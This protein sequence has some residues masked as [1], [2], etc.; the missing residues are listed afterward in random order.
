M[1][2]AEE[3]GANGVDVQRSGG[4][5]ATGELQG[6]SEKGEADAECRDRAP[7]ARV[8]GRGGGS[9]TAGA[10]EEHRSHEDGVQPRARLGAER[11]DDVLVGDEHAL[12]REIEQDAAD[13]QPGDRVPHAEYDPRYD[14]EQRA[15]EDYPVRPAL[16][17]MAAGDGSGEDADRA[18]DAEQPGD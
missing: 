6:G 2:S 3:E 4:L 8:P 1:P 7:A 18:D 17:R 13:Y 11:V 16:V 12:H 5:A 9:R 10:A 14:R 15:G